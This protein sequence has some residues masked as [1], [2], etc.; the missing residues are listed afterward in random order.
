[1]EYRG[2]V[3]VAVVGNV[4]VKSLKKASKTILGFSV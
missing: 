3:G 4:A 2:V 1:M